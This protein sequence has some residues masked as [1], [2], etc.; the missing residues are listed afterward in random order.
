M[1]VVSLHDAAKPSLLARPARAR[2]ES[3][4]SSG[5]SSPA[6]ITLPSLPC[7][8][9]DQAGTGLHAAQQPAGMDCPNPGPA[10]RIQWRSF[11]WYA[12][13][14]C[15]ATERHSRQKGPWQGQG[16]RAIEGKQME[17]WIRGPAMMWFVARL[18]RAGV[19][20]VPS[21]GGISLHD[22]H[23]RSWPKHEAE[24]SRAAASST[25]PDPATWS[26]ILMQRESIPKRRHLRHQ[27]EEGQRLN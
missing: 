24:R 7:W 12:S 20:P 10:K 22:S 5:T 3:L 25:A 18:H 17:E 4:R 2:D 1:V 9:P 19:L 13:A 14:K 15:P 27:I 21:I 8:P 6:F 26:K 11:D 16:G 23:G